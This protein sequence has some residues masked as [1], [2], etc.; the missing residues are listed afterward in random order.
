M[1]EPHQGSGSGRPAIEIREKGHEVTAGVLLEP[2]LTVS[3]QGRSVGD[4]GGGPSGPL[5][6]CRVDARP[7]REPELEQRCPILKGHR[8]DTHRLGST[9][10][11]MRR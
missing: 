10:S 7:H 8:A 9:F 5:L 4:A 11:V 1:V 3:E 6:E 2:P